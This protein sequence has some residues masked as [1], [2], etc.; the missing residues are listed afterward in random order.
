MIVRSLFLVL[1]LAPIC[2]GQETPTEREAA[3][4][5]IAKLNAL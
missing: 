5:V 3:R 1:I 4:E 2:L